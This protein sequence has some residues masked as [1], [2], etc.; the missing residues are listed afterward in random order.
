MQRLR[1]VVMN[2]PR[3]LKDIVKEI[4]QA[5]PDMEVTAHCDDGAFRFGKCIPAPS[6]A[7]VVIL[8][9]GNDSGLK[10]AMV[11][12]QDGNVVELLQ[13][14]T[15]ELSPKVLVEALREVVAKVTEG[16]VPFSESSEPPY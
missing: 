13:L 4:V 10:I 7:D 14:S 1:I 2:M 3:L 11:N 12:S 16:S 9:G 5:E 8:G 6:R 15:L